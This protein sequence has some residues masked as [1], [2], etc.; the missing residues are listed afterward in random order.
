MR[1]NLTRRELLILSAMAPTALEPLAA[2]ASQ[3]RISP[4]VNTPSRRP[5][6]AGRGREG[7][8]SEFSSASLSATERR[9]AAAVSRD[10]RYLTTKGLLNRIDPEKYPVERNPASPSALAAAAA[11][12]IRPSTFRRVGTRVAELARDP[13]RM[14]RTIGLSNISA[15]QKAVYTVDRESLKVNPRRE[16]EPPPSPKYR[17]A[18]FIL[19]ALDCRDETDPEGGSD[20]MILG[21][22]VIDD[23]AKPHVL[24]SQI[25]GEFDDGVYA[26]FGTIPLGFFPLD[27]SSHWPKTFY[28]I[29]HLVESDSDDKAV[30]EAISDGVSFVASIVATAYGGAAAGVVAGAV[31]DMIGDFI[32]MFIDEDHLR[33]YGMT[34]V[35]NADHVM[36]GFNGAAD[37]DL[38]TGNITGQGAQYRVGVRWHLT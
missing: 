3:R 4:T 14:S 22:M 16:E 1:G 29:F 34:Q 33:P 35:F 30:A 2:F 28:P 20:S 11:Q 8:A 13:S 10:L 26:G 18:D 25:C 15:L 24:T 23:D 21:G 9:Q 31:V 37:L 32:G 7:T 5:G 27:N 12:R 38:A 6:R 17:R 36:N 19:R